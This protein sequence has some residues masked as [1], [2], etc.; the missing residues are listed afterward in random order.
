MKMTKRKQR[1]WISS[2]L[3]I[4]LSIRAVTY[5]RRMRISDGDLIEL[6][7][8]ELFISN[9]KK[10][11]RALSSIVELAALNY[12]GSVDDLMTGGAVSHAKQKT[13]AKVPTNLWRLPPDLHIRCA[14]RASHLGVSYDELL[15][16][17]LRDCFTN[18][19]MA[20][21]MREALATLGTMALN[22]YLEKRQPPRGAEADQTPVARLRH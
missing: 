4:D 9:H 6:A 15:E 3:P 18:P 21:S 20:P 5:A 11:Q 19:S 10:W 22:D 13:K 2:A 8:D 16:V 14:A 12:L 7:L 1:V 17:A